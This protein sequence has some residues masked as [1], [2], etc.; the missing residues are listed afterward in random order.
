[1]FEPWQ[2]PLKDSKP[3]ALQLANMWRTTLRCISAVSRLIYRIMQSLECVILALFTNSKVLRN[4]L[5][6]EILLNSLIKPQN[7]KTLSLLKHLNF[8]HYSGDYWLF[9]SEINRFKT[10]VMLTFNC[11][12]GICCNRCNRTKHRRFVCLI[13]LF[14]KQRTDNSFFIYFSAKHYLRTLDN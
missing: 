5:Q 13:W 9:Q 10:F 2:G 8:I 1:M 12:I 11:W 14:L 6:M 3:G 4:C 7:W